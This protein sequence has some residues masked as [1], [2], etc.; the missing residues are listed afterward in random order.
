MK[1]DVVPLKVDD[2]DKAAAI[3][4]QLDQA[5]VRMNRRDRAAVIDVAARLLKDKG[6]LESVSLSLTGG[7]SKVGTAAFH[8]FVR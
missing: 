5:M 2:I 3:L 4:V 6:R 8:F 7:L 1:A